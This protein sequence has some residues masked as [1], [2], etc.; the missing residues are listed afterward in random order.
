M[1]YLMIF[2][3]FFVCCET[4]GTGSWSEDIDELDTRNDPL[5]TG[6][7]DEDPLDTAPF[8]TGELDEDPLDTG[9]EDEPLDTS[10][11]DTG[12]DP[13]PGPGADCLSCEEMP[14]F[15]DYCQGGNSLLLYRQKWVPF[16]DGC[17]TVVTAKICPNECVAEWLID[18]E[19]A[20]YAH[21][22][23]I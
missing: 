23:C 20:Q 5:D 6:D 18:D 14:G 10:E 17:A 19:G 15:P 12:L 9:D 22:Y 4:S 21:H 11:L 13:N 16:R 8:D 1:K 3:L 2:A 7:E